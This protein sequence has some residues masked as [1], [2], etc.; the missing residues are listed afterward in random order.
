MLTDSFKTLVG[1]ERESWGLKADDDGDSGYDPPVIPISFA[2][3]GPGVGGADIVE[4]ES[5]SPGV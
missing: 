4:E 1:L 3:G 2:S 5:D